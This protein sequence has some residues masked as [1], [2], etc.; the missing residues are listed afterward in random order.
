M[1]RFDVDCILVGGMS[2]RVYG[3]TVMT[4]DSD[5]VTAWSRPSLEALCQAL[6]AAGSQVR[7]GVDEHG[8]DRFASLPGGIDVDDIRHLSSFRVRTRDGDLIDVLRSIPVEGGDGGRRL[9]YAALLEGSRLI[10]FGDG[11]GIRIVGRDTLIASKRAIGRR[12]D[13]QAVRDILA[14]SGPGGGDAAAR[15]NRDGGPSI[16]PL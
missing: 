7:I 15:R 1:Q 14:R 5:I 8:L 2:A 12:H 4:S 6:N 3:S 10:R 13:L 9:D 16:G 11:V